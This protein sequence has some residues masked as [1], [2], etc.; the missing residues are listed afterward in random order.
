MPSNAQSVQCVVRLPHRELS[1]QQRVS[2]R[3]EVDYLHALGAQQAPVCEVIGAHLPT[4]VLLTRWYEGQHLHQLSGSGAAAW[5]PRIEG[6]L[7]QLPPQT[8]RYDPL[9]QLQE[10]DSIP[11]W[12]RILASSCGNWLK[13]QA[14]QM[15]PCHNDLNPFNLL[16]SNA[17]EPALIILD[18]EMAGLNHPGFD[19]VTAQLG[20]ARE[21]AGG[22]DRAIAA[23]QHRLGQETVAWLL[24]CYWLREWAWA[25]SQLAEGNRLEAV[26]KQASLA[27]SEL[28]MLAAI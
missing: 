5:L 1:S 12:I 23:L 2:F 11:G 13:S 16:C 24:R 22:Y 25:M 7:A 8:R 3:W 20:L 15:Q 19:L 4:G 6:A 17:G 27:F 21:R 18:W 28:Q 9:A 26:Q 14:A 10:L